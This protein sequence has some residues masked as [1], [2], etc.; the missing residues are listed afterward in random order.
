MA[1]RIGFRCD[2]CKNVIFVSSEYFSEEV[3]CPNCKKSVEIPYEV[4]LKLNP[5][6][7]LIILVGFVAA[8]VY[9]LVKHGYVFGSQMGW[10]GVTAWGF[11]LLMTYF[12]SWMFIRGTMEVIYSTYVRKL[13]AAEQRRFSTRG[14][15]AR[16]AAS[17]ADDIMHS[18]SKVACAGLFLLYWR[19]V[20]TD[21]TVDPIAAIR[22]PW[23]FLLFGLLLSILLGIPLAWGAFRYSMRKY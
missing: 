12:V 3:E 16:F 22:D 8:L 13:S 9:A 17:G 4:Y 23:L 21:S 10:L 7:H 14:R 20:P 5:L 15:R 18:I 2:E 19:T 1:K 6:W 11:A